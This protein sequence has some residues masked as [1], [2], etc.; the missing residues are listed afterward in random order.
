MVGAKVD[1]QIG[2]YWPTGTG[3]AFRREYARFRRA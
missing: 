2:E 1:S 3:S